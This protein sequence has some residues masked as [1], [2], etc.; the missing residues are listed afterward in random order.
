MHDVDVRSS[1]WASKD[2]SNTCCHEITIHSQHMQDSH[3][4]STVCFWGED[5]SC[6]PACWLLRCLA[7][8]TFWAA[9]C[10]F[11]GSAALRQGELC[12]SCPGSLRSQTPGAAAGFR[13]V[14]LTRVTH[15]CRANL[16]LS[17][18][19]WWRLKYTRR[20]VTFAVLQ[21]AHPEKKV[22]GYPEEGGYILR[23]AESS[24]IGV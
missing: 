9:P 10:V 21:I 11:R 13:Q 4:W 14:K 5:V 18:L 8:S 15:L 22:A 23:S 7:F 16:C 6:L 17:E 19:L 1:V 12:S 24:S 20:P 2:M 3:L